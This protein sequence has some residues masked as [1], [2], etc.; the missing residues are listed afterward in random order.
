MAPAARLIRYFAA[1][2]DVFF[3]SADAVSIFLPFLLLCIVGSTNICLKRF[4]KARA[5]LPYDEGCSYLR[6]IACGGDDCDLYYCLQ[7]VC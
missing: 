1:D 4:Q 6:I 3:A 7:G 2:F 5:K